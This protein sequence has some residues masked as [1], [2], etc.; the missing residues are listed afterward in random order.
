LN[1]EGIKILPKYYKQIECLHYS[2]G[3]YGR[4]EA[5][6]V[7]LNHVIC[8]IALTKDVEIEDFC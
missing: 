2:Y 7:N 3:G 1:E 6:L 5:N 4:H 8:L